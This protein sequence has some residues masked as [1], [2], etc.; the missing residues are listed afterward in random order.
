MSYK[1]RKNFSGPEILIQAA[2]VDEKKCTT[3]NTFLPNPVEKIVISIKNTI[4]FTEK[5]PIK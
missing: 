5:L 2:D 1:M 3:L 4:M